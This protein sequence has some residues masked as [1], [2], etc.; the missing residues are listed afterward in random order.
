MRRLW[1]YVFGAVWMVALFVLAFPVLLL[2]WPSHVWRLEVSR[3]YSRWWSRGVLWAAGIRLV[4]RGREHLATRPAVF[5]F[6]HANMLD[7][8]VNACFAPRG[9]LVFGKRELARVPF[10]G[11]MWLC[12]G[13]PM[14]QRD[15]RDQWQGLLDSVTELLRQGHSTIVA[16]EG[17][18]SRHGK[19]L[20]FK[21]G[22]FHF[23]LASGAPIVPV[24]IR[25]GA[26]LYGAHGLRPGTV[27]VD[28]LPPISTAGWTRETLDE[29][30][31]E[32]RAV[33]LEHM[34]PH[35]EEP[36]GAP[37][38]AAEAPQG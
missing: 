29:H 37:A 27:E 9:C 15:Q 14:I 4:L 6:N 2:G 22:P 34:E 24:I 33:F 26:E 35:D 1:S 12:G 17:T 10:L 19:L 11:W 5:A 31:A 8:F 38:S 3:L 20:P 13:H 18:R 23:A 28:V 25:G 36:A 30:V 7:F 32:V 16:P 21:K